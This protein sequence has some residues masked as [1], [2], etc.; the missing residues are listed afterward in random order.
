MTLTTPR[1]P[2]RYRTH[3]LAF[4]RS[5]AGSLASCSCGWPKR[6]V[7]QLEVDDAHYA[8]A[9]HL[10][11]MA[12]RRL[13]LRDLVDPVAGSDADVWSALAAHRER[14]GDEAQAVLGVALECWPERTRNRGGGR[15]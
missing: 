3:E 12:Y 10:A 4:D 11:S 6:P 13:A 7:A 8:G 2:R 1:R 9:F 5:D 15:W 14:L